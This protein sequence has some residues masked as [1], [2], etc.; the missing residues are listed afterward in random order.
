MEIDTENK[1][2]LEEISNR[3]E[4]TMSLEKCRKRKQLNT[5]KG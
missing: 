3:I 2:P 4:K 5:D 1:Q